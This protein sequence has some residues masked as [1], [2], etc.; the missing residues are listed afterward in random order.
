MYPVDVEKVVTVMGGAAI[1]GSAVHSVPELA[2]A[3]SEGLPRAVVREVAAAAAPA[4]A[5]ARQRI[6]NLI[7]SAA[8]LKRRERLS[9]EA[10]ERAERLA[11]VTALAHQVLAGQQ[12][13]EDWLTRPHMLFGDQPPIEYAASELGA[14]WVE[15]VLHNIEYGLPV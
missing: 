7:T 9:P 14:R 5:Q 1:V 8:T 6:S 12:R 10:S 2:R 4:S 15:R 13:A 3:V 11:R